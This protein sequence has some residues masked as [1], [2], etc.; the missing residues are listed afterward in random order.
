MKPKTPLLTVDCV[1]FDDKAVVLIKRANSPY[2]GY[3]ALP[4]GFVEIGETVENAC[5]RETREETGLELK[6]VQLIGVYSEPK[7]DPNKHTVSVAFLGK[8]DISK[9]KAGSDALE[10]EIVKNWKEKSIA[11]DHKEIIEDAWN[12]ISKNSNLQ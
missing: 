12:T 2:K 11:F 8:A 3:Y 7:R 5:I 4:G 10:V 6:D 9:I 1:I